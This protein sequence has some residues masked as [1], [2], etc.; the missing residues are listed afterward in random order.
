MKVIVA[1][2]MIRY[3]LAGM[4]MA[5]FHYVLG[6]S[7]LGHQV[8]YV[9]ESGWPDACYDPRTG[10]YSNDPSAGFN[11]LMRLA[12]R[13]G[14]ESTS[15]CYVDRESGEAS[16]MSLGDLRGHLESAD[17]LLNIG[18]T[19]SL[20]EFG[21]CNRRALID[22]DPV[23]T[24][25][26][27]FGGRDL[28]EYHA[29]FS[30]GANIGFS[31]CSVPDAGLHWRPTVPPVVPELWSDH[32]DQPAESAAFTTIC[33]WNAYGAIE[34]AGEHYGQKDE[35]FIRLGDM[36]RRSPQSLELALAGADAAMQ[37]TLR[38]WGWKLR[39]AAEVT[40][41]FDAYANYIFQSRGEFSA[42]KHAYVQ[43]Q[44][45]WFSDRSVCY[46]ASGR[47]VVLQDTGIGRWLP[48][49]PAVLTFSTAQQAL[50][51]LE[52]MRSDYGLRCRSARDLANDFFGS[53]VVLPKLLEAA[54][55]S[56]SVATR[57][58]SAAD[59]STE[60]EI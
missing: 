36:P 60:D 13:F 58:D 2:Y 9:E 46:L 1:G 17:L 14:L 25:A 41:D 40:I 47:P 23:F 43:T 53:E 33:N 20:P 35:E 21:L 44:S 10:W 6:L 31:E 49:S 19:C 30:Y 42:A 52:S 4:M 7:R 37:A 24:Q 55:S 48:A 38:D 12:D 18:G 32:T 3:P 56:V 16:G 29:H 27:R 28:S 50:E 39:D 59:P 5:F 54:F 51:C 11:A 57:A 34:Y 26:G 15:V 22:M 45:G 8:V